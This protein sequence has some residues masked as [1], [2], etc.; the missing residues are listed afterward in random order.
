M[1]K[2][3]LKDELL[4]VQAAL[5]DDASETTVTDAIQLK[6]GVDPQ[7]GFYAEC[8]LLVTVPALSATILPAASGNNAA[9]S[10]TVA[11]QTSDTDDSDG[12]SGS[13]SLTLATIVGG[14]SG[15][16]AAQE[17][18]HRFLTD[19]KKFVRVSFTTNS[20]AT[21]ASAVTAEACLVF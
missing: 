7:G 5:P 13:T 10:L 17:I 1:A 15:G 9:G 16:A 11:I 18:R 2:L 8:E 20:T 12:W 21:D 14:T 3:T 19:V 4:C 6:G